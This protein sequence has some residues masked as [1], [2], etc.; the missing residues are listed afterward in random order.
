MKILYL[1]CAMGAAGDMLTAALL[2]LM[3]DKEAAV[4]E[5]N[6]LHI[7]GVVFQAEKN[8]KGG[9]C[10]THV[11]VLIDGEEEG[12]RCHSHSRME[13][14]SH[15]ISYLSA[16][17]RVKENAKAVY[18]KIAEAESAV[19]GVPVEMV[20]FH[21]VGAMDAVADV[22]AVCYLLEKLEADKICASPVHTGAGYVNCAHGTLPIP[23]PAT[24][25][26]LLGIPAYGGE[27][28]G[29]LCTPTGAALL[30]HFAEEFGPMPA[31]TVSAIGYGM[32]KK[33]FSRPN[34]LRA[35]VGE[36]AEAAERIWELSCNIDDMTGEEMGFA[37]EQLLAQGVLDVFTMPVYMKKN[38]P[39]ILLTVL[40]REEAKEETL[41]AIFRY[42]T[43]LGIREKKCGR[44]TLSR[45]EETEQTPWGP[46]RKKISEGCGVQ[47][48]KY[49]YEDLAK[50]AR[51]QET[52]LRFMKKAEEN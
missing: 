36:S 50:I 6:G 12:S 13:D 21:E 38:R 49:E 8:I 1:D 40:C 30:R 7:P 42:T 25:R 26:L 31:M 37:T 52:D 45:R 19:H 10:G 11:Q 4:A 17:D 29:E 23:A 43:T 14:I 41:R 18:E 22:A 33:D 2:E 3:P 28:Q 32:G 51:Q 47:R 48:S 35:M 39:G 24:A 20:H 16:S 44:Y 46:V 5:L 27:I 9:I 34:C 15:I